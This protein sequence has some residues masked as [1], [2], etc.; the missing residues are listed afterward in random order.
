[1]SGLFGFS[2]PHLDKNTQGIR[3][4]RMRDLLDNPRYLQPDSLYFSEII[5]GSRLIPQGP[6]VESQ[7]LKS[8]HSHLL[9][10]DGEL[11]N[12]KQVTGT[13]LLNTKPQSDSEWFLTN[14]PFDTDQSAFLRQLDG[15]FSAVLYNATSR[16]IVLVSDRFGQS[17]LF[18]SA[19]NGEF[20]WSAEQKGML[21][22]PNAFEMDRDAIAE[23]LAIGY[24]I[25]TK[26]WFRGVN[27]LPPA[28][29][30]RWKVE[31]RSIKQF[32]YWHWKQEHGSVGN[33]SPADVASEL[34]QRFTAAVETR[35]TGPGSLGMH[36][37]G[38]RD[39][40]AIL[41]AIPESHLDNFNTITFGILDSEDVRIARQV[42]RSR[43]INHTVFEIGANNWLAPRIEGVWHSDGCVSIK[44]M[45]SWPFQEDIK[46]LFDTNLS[47]AGGDGIFG[48]GHLFDQANL[49]AYARKLGLGPESQPNVRLAFE[50]YFSELGDS[51]A[52]Y[53]EHRIRRFSLNSAQLAKRVGIQWRFPF[54]DN[55]L[56]E[57]LY[58]VPIKERQSGALYNR[59]LLSAFPSLFRS[60]PW[61]QTGVPI[62]ASQLRLWLSRVTRSRKGQRL[63]NAI[64]LARQCPAH[65]PFAAYSEW[66]RARLNWRYFKEQL[67]SADSLI[68]NYVSR[69]QLDLALTAHMNGF[70]RS[71]ELCRYLT[72]EI[73]L[74]SLVE[75]R[76]QLAEDVLMPR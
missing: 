20:V 42:A 51:H 13:K 52:L 8:V 35:S 36:L 24:F 21:A 7:P 71:E 12:R 54:L 6:T 44:H 29:V 69:K 14:F 49:L 74:K 4:R 68:H 60:I 26:T 34:A 48:G 63:L 50:E 9:W 72:L 62:G 59:M 66:M 38:G 10:F 28:T 67:G 22:S 19:D 70:D 46:Q 17:C 75:Q 65:K 5:C 40:R 15:R 55:E 58:S 23:F 37:S 76:A 33:E 27:L 39:S 47:G 16:E 45:H 64:H 2:A 30:L 61:E 41:A 57:F 53:V 25:G 1:M 3:L 18:W 43:R 11:Y 56:Q 31:E 32:R 73:W